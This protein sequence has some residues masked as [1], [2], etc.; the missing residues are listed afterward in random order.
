VSEYVLDTH[1]CL[2]ALAA[3]AKLGRRARSALRRADELGETVWLPAAVVAEV[4]MLKELGRT[5]LGLPAL[6]EAF[7]GTCWR[8]LPL[9]LDQLDEFAALTGIR[10]PFDRLIVAATRRTGA[11]LISRDRRLSETGLVDVTWS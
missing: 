4:V 9:D 3:P 6:R 8:F 1:A 5:E 10:D 7:A 2:F 11:K